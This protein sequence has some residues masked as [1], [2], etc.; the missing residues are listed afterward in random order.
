MSNINT[1]TNLFTQLPVVT[2]TIIKEVYREGGSHP[3]SIFLFFLFMS[4][5]LVY[6]LPTLK[7]FTQEKEIRSFKDFVL[8][9]VGI[10]GL[11]TTIFFLV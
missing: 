7:T 11:I 8:S 2:N 5:T 6:G 9:C 10:A 4:A 3:V 1:F